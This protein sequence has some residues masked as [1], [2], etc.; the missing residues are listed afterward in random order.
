MEGMEKIKMLET[1]L[2]GAAMGASDLVPG[3][4]G[5]TIA[6]ITGIYDRLIDAVHAIAPK[7]WRLVGR[8]TSLGEWWKAIDGMFL[9]CLGVGLLTAVFG[10]SKLLS[11][12]LATYPVYLWSF[13]FGLVG[14]SIISLS[15]GISWNG[16][17]VAMG[18]LGVLFGLLI[19]FAKP[20]T[21][22]P[23]LL[24]F[25]F[26][27]MIAITAMVLPGISGSFILLLLGLYGPVIQSVSERDFGVLAI[28]AA[29]AVTGLLLFIKILH[30]L[31]HK[32]HAGTI[33]FLTGLMLGTLPKVWPW[34]TALEE[35][36]YRGKTYALSESHYLPFNQGISA[37]LVGAFV[38]IVLGIGAILLLEKSKR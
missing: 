7:T 14:A 26:G 27:G 4:S 33:A 9:L 30:W 20:F 23:G 8:K 38:L 11:F 32:H 24:T 31:L 18:A 13:F 17:A 28:F 25:F 29:G 12:V 1:A 6:F 16:K 2:K 21:L 19:V 36:T 10:L 35:V 37:E 22:A 15:K 3:V 5:G 34:R